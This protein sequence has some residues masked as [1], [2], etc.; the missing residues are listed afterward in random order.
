MSAS[1]PNNIRYD[2]V[3]KGL[4]VFIEFSAPHAKLFEEINFHLS[5]RFAP[6]PIVPPHCTLLYGM[7]ISVDLQEATDKLTR[8]CQGLRSF[9]LVYQRNEYVVHGFA[10]LSSFYL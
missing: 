1:S 6:S 9:P 4:S 5:K 3:F 10:F 7:D 2:F 8:L